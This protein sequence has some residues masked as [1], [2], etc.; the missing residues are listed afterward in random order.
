M[1]RASSATPPGLWA[2]A[3][4]GAVGTAARAGLVW[5]LPA[6][7]GGFPATVFMVNVAGALALGWLVGRWEL[8]AGG[9]PWQLPFF[10]TGLLGSFTTFSALALDVAALVG[11]RPGVALAYAAAS[12]AVGWAAAAAGWSLGRGRA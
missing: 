5:L 9:P 7:A 2:V 8:R 10:A 4:G 1:S 3:A 6:Q 11:P 12:V